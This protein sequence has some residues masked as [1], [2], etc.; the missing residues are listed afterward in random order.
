VEIVDEH[1]FATE[2]PPQDGREHAAVPARGQSNAAGHA[3]HSVC[4]CRDHLAWLQPD[5]HIC[6]GRTIADF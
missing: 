2:E 6:E 4:L 5:K 3:G 1:R